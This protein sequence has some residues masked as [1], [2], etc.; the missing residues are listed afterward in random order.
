MYR[1]RKEN[2]RILRNI[3]LEVTEEELPKKKKK[4]KL[5]RRGQKARGK[6]SKQ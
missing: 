1:E 3:G 4:K 5:S 6:T 2:L